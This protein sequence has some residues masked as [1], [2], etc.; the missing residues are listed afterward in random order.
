MKRLIKHLPT[1][2][3]GLS[4]FGCTPE[5]STL[6]EYTI[7][8]DLDVPVILKFLKNGEPNTE[9]P[10]V[11]LDSFGDSFKRSAETLGSSTSPFD[12]FNSDSILIIFD[13]NSRQG[14][15]L[16]EPKGSSLLNQQ[17]Y[18]RVDTGKFLYRIGQ[19]NLSASVPCENACN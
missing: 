8:N 3:I 16:F 5:Q 10:L 19:E 14:H 12:V 15:N 18:Q 4:L 17:D 6:S 1:I 7:Q 13:G 9:I 2:L 11:T